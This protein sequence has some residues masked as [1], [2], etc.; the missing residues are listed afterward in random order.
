MVVDSLDPVAILQQLYKARGYVFFGGPEAFDLNLC[1]IRVPSS[2]NTFDDLLG[3]AYRD[4]VG[5]P[6]ILEV[7][8]GT[9]D[10][11]KAYLVDPAAGV[12]G[13]AILVAAQY[14]SLWKLGYHRESVK[15]KVDPAF[16]QQGSKPAKVFRDG[17]R[18]S[19][20]DMDPA[21]IVEGWFGINGHKAGPDSAI[22]DRHSA[23]CQVW[24]R[25]VDHDRALYLGRK[26]VELHPTWTEFTYTLFD[27]RQDPLA[28]A[29]FYAAA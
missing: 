21:T 15:G 12:S 4:V 8:P 26:Q 10:P 14:R 1:G 5:G 13:T 2:S 18:D 29:L 3:C 22:V 27:V 9:T 11:G 28:E 16:V 24:K 23:G 7:W 17:N 25:H 20:L 6:L 19:V